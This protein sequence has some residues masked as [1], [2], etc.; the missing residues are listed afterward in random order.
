MALTDQTVITS[1]S[2]LEDGQMQIR[3]TRRILDGTDL[4]GE[5]HVRFVLEPGQ[6]VSAQPPRVQA[7]CGVVWT[8]A[9]IATYLAAKTV[10]AGSVG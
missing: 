6:D 2:I 9:V 8:P 4:I 7:V 10:N 1:I 5:R 3:R